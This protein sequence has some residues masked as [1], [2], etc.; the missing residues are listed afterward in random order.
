MAFNYERTYKQLFSE[1]IEG[2]I[3]LLSS[4][5]NEILI[6]QHPK[7]ALSNT[8]CEEVPHRGSSV[9]REFGQGTGVS[10]SGQLCSRQGVLE[11]LL[12]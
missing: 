7:H 11:L 10:K 5:D 1:F 2:V 4:S 3:V 8:G 9:G 12:S 6:D